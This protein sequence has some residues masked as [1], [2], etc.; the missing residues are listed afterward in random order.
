MN[1][2]RLKN[3]LSSEE[4]NTLFVLKEELAFLKRKYNKLY[5]KKWLE[6]RIKELENK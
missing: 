4:W 3:N 6:K 1:N 2:H 5:T